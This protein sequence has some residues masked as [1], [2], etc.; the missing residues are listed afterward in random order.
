MS[1]LTVEFNEE[2]SSLLKELAAK[3]GTTRIEVLRRALGLYKY[4]SAEAG[5]TSGNQL[6]ITKAGKVVQNI[7]LS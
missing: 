7:I 1:K 5:P 3:K 6:S 2:V 4:T